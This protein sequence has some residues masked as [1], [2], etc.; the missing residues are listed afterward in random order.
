MQQREGVGTKSGRPYKAVWGSDPIL[1][2]FIRVSKTD[3]R[4]GDH[5][6]TLE[7]SGVVVDTIGRSQV[8]VRISSGRHKGVE[9]VY[10]QTAIYHT[11]EN[12]IDLAGKEAQRMRDI[13]DEYGITNF[14]VRV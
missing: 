11:P 8:V 9:G 10:A 14:R 2:Y 1:G 13:L 6:L 12:V 4:P 3:F 5:V 7:G